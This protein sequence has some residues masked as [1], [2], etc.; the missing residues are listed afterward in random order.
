MNKYLFW[1]VL[2]TH[3]EVSRGVHVTSSSFCFIYRHHTIE[4]T[5]MGAPLDV[6]PIINRT[7]VTREY[8]LNPIIHLAHKMSF[9]H[10]TT[11]KG[12]TVF[13]VFLKDL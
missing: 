11:A 12:F 1:H 8:G 6:V 9:D 5:K 3:E 13:L 10:A 4:E 2:S 7:R